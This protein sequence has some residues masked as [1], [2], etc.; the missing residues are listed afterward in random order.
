MLSPY[1]VFET[2]YRES[3]TLPGPRMSSSVSRQAFAARLDQERRRLSIRAIAKVADVP[4]TTA[5]GWLN[6]RHFPTPALRGRLRLVTEL[7]TGP[8][9]AGRSLGGLARRDSAHPAG[10]RSPYLGLRSFAVTDSE[11]FYGRASQSGRIADAVLE[12]AEQ[13]TALI[14]LVGPSWQQ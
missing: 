12:M 7:R 4:A 2:V 11:L 1:K 6:G 5:Q 9:D 13:A 14:A 10:R 8:R 3:R